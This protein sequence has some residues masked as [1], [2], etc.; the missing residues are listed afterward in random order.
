M[1]DRRTDGLWQRHDW[2]KTRY[3]ELIDMLVLDI[4]QGHVTEKV[5]THI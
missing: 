5:K 4:R 1:D 3:S 2:G